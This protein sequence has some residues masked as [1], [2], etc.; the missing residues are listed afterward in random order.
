MHWKSDRLY[1]DT[2][3]TPKYR[4]YNYVYL[5]LE[6]WKYIINV[7]KSKHTIILNFS[8]IEKKRMQNTR[9]FQK[10]R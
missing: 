7:L 3:F 6:S 10:K 4:A 8:D 5:F 1:W 9:E 2:C